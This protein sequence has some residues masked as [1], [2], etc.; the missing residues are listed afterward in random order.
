MCSCQQ[1]NAKHSLHFLAPVLLILP[2]DFWN[3]A[4]PTWRF[5]ANVFW[6]FIC[7]IKIIWRE[8]FKQLQE[9]HWPCGYSLEEIWG[10]CLNGGYIN[11]EDH[12]G[13]HQGALPDLFLRPV[14]RSP[15]IRDPSRPGHGPVGEEKACFQYISSCL[16]KSPYMGTLRMLCLPSISKSSDR[17][18]ILG[19]ACWMNGWVSKTQK[20]F[21][22]N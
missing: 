21:L 20:G 10:F 3:H 6:Y 11:Y 14:E 1:E 7:C 18:W 17:W 5:Q 15:L 22:N 2:G 16:T 12:L 8:R 9:S 13:L 19:N 4:K